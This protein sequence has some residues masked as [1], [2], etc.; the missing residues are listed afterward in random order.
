MKKL[1]I[2]LSGFLLL[3]AAGAANAAL[4]TL[5]SSNLSQTVS[6]SS[7]NLS[8]SANF[9]LDLTA[10]TLTLILTNTSSQA[11]TDPANLLSAIFWSSTTP[12]YPCD[13]PPHQRQH[14]GRP[15]QYCAY[16]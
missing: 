15:P 13:R 12:A 7:G 8:D 10:H 11:L 2:L 4:I 14:L 1:S 6:A 5:D 3:A 16:S 9:T